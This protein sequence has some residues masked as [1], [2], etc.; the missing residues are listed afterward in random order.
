LPETINHQKFKIELMKRTLFIAAAALLFSAAVS[1]QTDSLPTQQPT[2]TETVRTDKY[3]NIPPDKYKMAPMPEALTTE[4]IFPVLGKYQVTNKE[5]VTSEVTVMQD[6]SNK[7]TV[8]IEG[9]PTGKIKANLRKSPAVYRIP[10]QK[11]G[12]DPEAKDAKE[13]AEG[14]LVYDKDNNTLN[15]CVGCKFNAEDPASAFAAPTEPVVEEPAV[16]TKKKTTAK[17]S[18]K[19]KEPKVKPEFY[20]GTKIIETTMTPATTPAT[21]TPATDQ[22]Q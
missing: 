3:N 15:V 6:A 17:K 18:T 21:T 13:I 1:A 19:V 7:G 9:L 12:E 20:T 10:V 11:I 2:S 14:V 16:T 4:K 8:W 22:Q 5:G